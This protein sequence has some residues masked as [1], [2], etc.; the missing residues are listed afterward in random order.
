VSNRSFGRFDGMHVYVIN[1][2]RAPDRLAHMQDQLG[3]LGISFSRVKAVDA[4]LMTEAELV[5]FRSS[6][7]QAHR[8]H[9]WSP[10]QI[11]IFLSH[12]KAWEEIASGS[13]S[14]AAVLEDDV[15]LSDRIVSLLQDSDWI[16]QSMDIVRLET[17]LQGVRLS[18]Q[19]VSQV[20]DM[21]IFRVQG[22]WGSAG[23]IISRN[24]A[25]WLV[26]SPRRVYEPVDWL[27]F[28]E[29]SA[30]AP[31]LNIFQLDPAPCVQDQYHPDVNSRR[32]FDK[33]TQ[34]PTGWV[35]TLETASRRVLSPLARKATGRRGIPFA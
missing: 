29:R 25:A 35:Y 9:A 19:P 16:D 14:H 8:P 12:K 11:G 17:T 7:V 24:I 20:D 27:L 23:Y 26:G 6:I 15:H 28:H 30:L 22:A 13:D 3:R 31:A 32:N 21:K 10:A 18:R 2:D 4:K 1:L 34:V 33:V 5:E